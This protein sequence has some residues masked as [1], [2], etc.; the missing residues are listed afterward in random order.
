MSF[1]A[2]AL[3]VRADA[4]S[5]LGRFDIK[6]LRL[7]DTTLILPKEFDKRAIETDFLALKAATRPVKAAKNSPL[8]STAL[9]KRKRQRGWFKIQKDSD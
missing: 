4:F 8:L 3:A 1:L 5:T 2:H 6:H 9:F 7:K